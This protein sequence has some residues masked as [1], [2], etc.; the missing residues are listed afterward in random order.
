M[1]NKV[2][3][4]L[5]VTLFISL[6]VSAQRGV[7]I[8]YIDTEYILENVP[9]YQD[10]SL[11]LDNKVTQWQKEIEVELSKIELKKEELEKESVLL[12]KELYD[13]RMD[14]ILFEE[15][16]IIDYQ[17]KIFGPSGALIVQKR[18]LIAPVQDQIFAAVQEIAELKKFDFVFDKSADV[19]MLYSAERYDISDQVLK[20]I[21]RTSKRKQTKNKKEREA[22]ENEEVVPEVDK[23]LDAKQKER[24]AQKAAKEKQIENKKIQRAKDLEE[25]KKQQDS[26]RAAKR[27]EKAKRRQKAIE[28]RK[29][30]SSNQNVKDVETN[31]TE[32]QVNKTNDTAKDLKNSTINT[33]EKA[34][35]PKTAAEIA[36]EK[37]Q[38]KLK[39]R[40]ARKKALDDRKNKILENKKRLREERL[41]KIRK[42]DSLAKA[43]KN[44]KQ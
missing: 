42:R 6:Y 16:K 38:Q 41:E 29:K 1:K 20:T 31:D 22:L 37:K 23:E 26:I 25:R 19:V 24:E 36:E 40:E 32:K 18:Q 8:G 4:L 15:S 14:D 13:E 33:E 5:T 43:K 12:T 9:E 34:N 2:L 17:Q 35:V 11:Q 7:R 27:D 3:F 39:D 10:A 30:K 28:A 44:K 21:T